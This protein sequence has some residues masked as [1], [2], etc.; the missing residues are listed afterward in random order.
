MR[1]RVVGTRAEAALLVDLVRLAA[2]VLEVSDPHPCRG[3]AHLV[4]VYLYAGPHPEGRNR[5]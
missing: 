3:S 4:R 1:I 2:E 5:Q